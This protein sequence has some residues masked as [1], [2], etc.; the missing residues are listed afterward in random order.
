MKKGVSKKEE[1]NIKG[2]SDPSICPL[3]LIKPVASY[4]NLFTV[5]KK[6]FKGLYF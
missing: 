3:C 6:N 5:L 2:R 1:S 4:S